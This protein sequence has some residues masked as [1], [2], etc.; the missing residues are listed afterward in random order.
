MLAALLPLAAAGAQQLTLES[1]VEGA[2]GRRARVEL[3][4]P[5]RL[6][7]FALADYEDDALAR[8]AAGVSTP[9]LVAGPLAPAG[10]LRL[11]EAP[12]ACGPAAD[13]HDEA[14]GLLLDGSFDGSSRSGAIAW[15]AP[16]SLGVG[17]WGR[18]GRLTAVLAAAGRPLPPLQWEAALARSAPPADAAGEDWYYGYAPWRGGA[19]SHAAA[20]LRADAGALAVSAAAAASIAERAAP[21]AWLL[22]R[23]EA[24]GPQ[25][26]ADALLG[27][28]N[29]AYRDTG[30][31]LERTLRHAALRVEARSAAAR[32][33]AE[34]R[35]SRGLEAFGGEAPWELAGGATAAVGRAKP[36]LSL[37]ASAAWKRRRDA[38]GEELSSASFDASAAAE[39]GAFSAE[40]SA[41]SGGR[42][43]VSGRWKG[44]GT[45]VSLEGCWK[46]SA[47]DAVEAAWRAGADAARLEIA[48]GW[49]AGP[50]ARWLLS[51]RW[52]RNLG[53]REPQRPSQS[54]TRSTSRSSS[55]P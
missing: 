17:A 26:R 33:S 49:L 20:R 45:E 48:A 25:V 29:G 54:P 43:A 50:P 22:A 19:L 7:V 15:P 11:I 42:I 40:A 12:F 51:I 9:W 13:V 55:K 27:L 23:L 4:E 6:R 21:G 3:E 31:G 28:S 32:L 1:C 18:D 24:C 8:A 34:A 16:G 41:A 35:G 30:G 47:L 38:A 14:T 2:G 46:R 5:E 39:A 36:A 44:R 37:E 52:R 10:L 53:R